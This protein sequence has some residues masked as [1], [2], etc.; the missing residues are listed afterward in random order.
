[1]NKITITI[2]ITLEF[3]KIKQKA[4]DIQKIKLGKSLNV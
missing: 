4:D 1:M 3:W 2:T